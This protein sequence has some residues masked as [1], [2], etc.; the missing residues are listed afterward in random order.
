MPSDPILSIERHRGIAVH[1]PL[2]Q[3]EAVDLTFDRSVDQGCVIAASGLRQSRDAGRAG[4]GPA[5]G[6]MG[7][8][9]RRAACDSRSAL[10]KG[11][12]P[13]TSLWTWAAF[14]VSLY[15]SNTHRIRTMPLCVCH[16]C[17]RE[18]NVGTTYW[19]SCGLLIGGNI[20]LDILDRL[21]VLVS[22]G[23]VLM[24][25]ALMSFRFLSV[26]LLNE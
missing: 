22:Y 1:L 16:A 25:L 8:T 17:G 23:V 12:S 15:S 2:D 20:A 6:D 26:L 24:F 5:L 19:L 10:R 14:T 9:C 18:S 11:S 7:R 4:S 3:L 21:T 13:R